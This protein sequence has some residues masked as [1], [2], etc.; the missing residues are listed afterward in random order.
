[1]AVPSA[2]QLVDVNELLGRVQAMEGYKSTST[3]VPL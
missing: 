2:T 3:V 1:V